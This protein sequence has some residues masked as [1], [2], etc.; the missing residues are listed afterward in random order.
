MWGGNLLSKGKIPSLNLFLNQYKNVHFPHYFI[1]ASK[2][3]PESQQAAGQSTPTET[4]MQE[5]SM[6]WDLQCTWKKLFL[7]ENRMETLKIPIPVCCLAHASHSWTS[8][9][10]RLH[11]N[12]SSYLQ[13]QSQWQ[14]WPSPF[15]GS[16]LKDLITS[17]RQKEEDKQIHKKCNKFTQKI[18]WTHTKIPG[19]LWLCLLR[20]RVI[21]PGLLADLIS[22]SSFK[23]F[24]F[25]SL[26]IAHI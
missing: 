25:H 10:P 15:T 20:T 3:G 1:N 22:T 23:W 5:S 19:K 13:V 21:F 12:I 18:N 11:V 8:D 14:L 7:P 6:A 16:S 4:S 24:L 17:A 9:L 26:S 2:K